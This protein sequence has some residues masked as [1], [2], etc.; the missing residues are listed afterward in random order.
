MK[1]Y[2]IVV[3]V[4]LVLSVCVQLRSQT[5]ISG[6]VSDAED[7]EPIPN[8]LIKVMNPDSPGREII[9]YTET[10]KNGEYKLQFNIGLNYIEVEFSLLG[11][12]RDTVRLKNEPQTLNRFLTV[13]TFA[14]REVTVKAPSISSRGDT[15]NYN[16]AAFKSGSDRTVEDILKKLPG[17]TVQNNGR[18]EYQGEAINKFYIEGLDMLGGRYN[19]ATQNITVDHIT[20]VQ[21]YE[22]HQPIRLLKDINLSDKAAIN[23][24]LKD[25]RMSRPKG[26]IMA[27]TGYSDKWLYQGD[28]FGF[29]AN[30]EVQMLLSGKSNN[31]SSTI[32]GELTSHYG[33]NANRVKASTLISPVSVNAPFPIGER[34]GYYRNVISSV[35]AIK[36]IDDYSNMKVNMSYQEGKAE[37]RRWI[38]SSY[39]TGGSEILIEENTQAGIKDKALSVSVNYQK[40]RDS[41]YINETL[42]GNL[43]I[44]DN[45]VHASSLINHHQ[46]YRM[47]QFNLNNRL[48]LMWRRGY[49]TYSIH[50]FVSGGDIP[51]NRLTIHS[52]N[53]EKPVEQTVSGHTIYTKHSTAFVKG[54]NAFSNLSIDLSFE[55]EYD[56]I[57]TDL[58]NK[59]PDENFLNRNR[60]YKLISTAL[61]AYTYSKN[62]FRLTL[63]SPVKYYNFRYKNNPDFTVDKPVIAPQL[64]VRYQL[65]PGF[66]INMSSG[67]DHSFGDILNFIEAPIQKSYLNLSQGESGVLA[68]NRRMKIN[69]GYDYRNT[70][71]GLFSTLLL[72]YNKTERNILNGSDISENGMVTA[73]SKAT[74][75]HS[76]NITSNLY[77]AK[78]FYNIRT[79]AS[80]T[81]NAFYSDNE[82]IRQDVR[83]KYTHGLLSFV[84]TLNFTLIEW[85]AVR[86]NGSFDFM[87]QKTNTENQ[88]LATPINNWGADMEL[89]VLPIKNL[90]I[91][92]NVNYSNR[93]LL[94]DKRENILF[95]DGGV[96]Y[97][98]LK[99]MELGLSFRNLTNEKSY[100]RAIYRELDLIKTTHFLRPLGCVFNVKINY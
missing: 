29:M 66:R 97:Q 50:S 12:K 43:D 76:N 5:V 14:L 67:I 44:G 25:N 90:E 84:P 4:L 73:F 94:E 79:V 11:Y 7:R 30:R 92:Y 54:F 31:I 27:G 1:K 80:L 68:Q 26:N 86:V 96:W 58:V 51:E 28:I 34:S 8:I 99:E 9:T 2:Q 89:S 10:N 40:N 6:I 41:L 48:D 56:R 33:E 91:Y 18:I 75:N 100:T 62:R 16:V 77:L 13:S 81:V 20:T 64:N 63:S 49:N 37:N 82:R 93:S 22:N 83:V 98:P 95:M 59:V 38:S 55:S 23:I 71:S 19:L 69:V 70:M 39:Y 15:I 45:N 46:R 42:G 57:F 35:N 60:G 47:K 78:N 87:R 52:S 74:K 53:K 21:V 17:I 3:I 61:L 85:L 32:R 72:G 88:N 36:K 65:T 24:K